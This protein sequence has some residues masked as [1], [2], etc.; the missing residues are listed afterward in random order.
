MLDR[1]SMPREIVN[2]V[3]FPDEEY[4][5]VNAAYLP[6]VPDLTFRHDAWTTA[7]LQKPFQC[8]ELNSTEA[9]ASN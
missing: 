5:S 2:N 6:E 1:E 4:G 7:R 8:G 3:E 9:R